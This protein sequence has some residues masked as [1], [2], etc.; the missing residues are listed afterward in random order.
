MS[1]RILPWLFLLPSAY[2]QPA[3]AARDA[4]AEAFVSASASRLLGV[5]AD[6]TAGPAQ[7]DAAFHKAIDELADVPRVT[8]FVLGKYARTIT[9]D[10]K[11]RFALAFRSY[12]ERIYQG[13]LADYGGERVS[14]VGS[15]TRKP[16]DVIVATEIG[17]GQLAR[18]VPVSWRILQ[19]PGG[20]RVV[21][22]QF[23]GVWLAITQQ[24]DFVA[25]IDNAGGDVE[26]LINRLR[27]DAPASVNRR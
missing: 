19:S 3:L 18:P 2:A 12:A 23:R 6:K 22:V 26:V 24:Q 27:S 14:V 13:R 15:V 7:K 21:D 1:R 17:G 20:W 16:G 25:T 4:G 9:P 5:L 10:Q 11:R 8:H